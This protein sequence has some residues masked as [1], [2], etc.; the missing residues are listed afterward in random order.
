MDDD[1]PELMK[2]TSKGMIRGLNLDKDNRAWLGIPYAKPPLGT[3]RLV[4]FDAWSDNLIAIRF[5]SGKLRFAPPEEPESWEDTIETRTQPNACMQAPDLAFGDFSGSTLW[6]PNTNISEDCLYLNVFAPRNISEV[7]RNI[8]FH[9]NERLGDEMLAS[10]SPFPS[11][12]GYSAEATPRAALHS[13]STTP[14]LSSPG[15]SSSWQ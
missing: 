15:T 3:K 14:P 7:G 4:F 2:K 12:C 10:V 5:F 8:F 13:T 11:S 1:D 9:S 6:N